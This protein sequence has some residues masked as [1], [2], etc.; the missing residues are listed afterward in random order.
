MGRPFQSICPITPR[1][2]AVG[3]AAIPPDDEP[4]PDI[5][6]N[7]TQEP[8]SDPPYGYTVLSIRI[9]NSNDILDDSWQIKANDINI[10]LFDGQP[11]TD[12]TYYAYVKKGISI[13]FTATVASDLS[14]NYFEVTLNDDGVQ[15]EFIAVTDDPP[16]GT[17][18]PLFSYET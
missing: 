10:V 15:V 11:E 3:Y 12:V 6:T 5:P 1:I 7:W 13:D 14:D 8:L 18:I 16:V 17:T 9:N 2:P 4:L